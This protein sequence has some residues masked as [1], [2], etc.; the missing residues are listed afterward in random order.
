M[1]AI[2]EQNAGK[3]RRTGVPRMK[4]HNL[5]TDMTPLVDL[6]F[7]LIAF[8]VFTAQLSEPVAWAV[9]SSR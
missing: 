2:I 8:F 5:K 7:L 6:G 4:K 9:A 3:G 1:A